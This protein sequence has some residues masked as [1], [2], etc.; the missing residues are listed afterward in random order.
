[1]NIMGLLDKAAAS[2]G[3]EAKPV[4]KAK[5]VAT[6]K[7]V[8]KAKAV[9]AKPARAEKPV[10]A[11]KAR[12]PR[13]RPVGLAE[14]YELATNMNRRISW[15][16]NFII[17]FGVLFAALF[18]AS[19]DTGIITTILFAT[20][21]GIIILNAVFIPMKFSRNLGQFVSRTKFIRGDG[22]N[23]LFLHGI[24]EN[25]KGLFALIGLISVATQFQ[26][27]TEADNTTAIVFFSMGTLFIIVWF[28]DRFL[29]NG[30]E[31]GQGLYDLL[32]G[33]Y[34]VKYVPS[35]DEKATGVW[36][37]LEN[38]GNFGDQL[39][40]RQEERKAK[41]EEKASEAEEETN[42]QED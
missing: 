2:G 6:A 36:A 17:N 26:K 8:A 21:G 42:P 22:S 39:L 25:T 15:L 29:R 11:K 27:L 14:D 10:K 7:P 4:A 40:K 23:P 34:L 3:E 13:A 5:P 24:L 16:V 19:S 12:A 31:M 1:M 32:F 30:S 28:V 18:I 20:S 37:R 35:E 41:K 9:K 38:M 33:A